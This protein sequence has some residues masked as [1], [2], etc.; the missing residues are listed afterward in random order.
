MWTVVGLGNPGLRY[1]STRHNMGFVFVK[2]LAK[3]LDAKTR[4]R[5]FSSKVGEG[6]RKGEKIFLAMPQTY[7]NNSG[8]AVKKILTG[9]R[10]ALNKLI[11]VYDDI[12][13]PL[14]EIRIRKEGSAGTHKGMQSVVRELETTAFPRI[15]IGIGPQSPVRDAV[16]FVLSSFEEEEKPLVEEGLKKARLA[17]EMIWDEGFQKA[18]NI[19][20]QRRESEI[21]SL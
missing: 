20:N 7:M 17:L 12:D 3:D 10:I 9:R 2:R 11:I 1:A 8:I 21:H 5:A 19:Y 14:G 18:M 4:K 13:I 6:E 15:R 16:D